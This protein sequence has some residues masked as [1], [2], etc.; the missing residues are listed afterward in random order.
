MLKT[1]I[2]LLTTATLFFTACNTDTIDELRNSDNS[3][4]EQIAKKDVVFIVK[5]TPEIICKSEDFKNAVKMAIDTYVEEKNTNISIKEIET[6]VEKNNVTCETYKPKDKL[7]LK[8]PLCEVKEATD[9]QGSYT[10]PEGIELN[11][12][13]NTSCVVTGDVL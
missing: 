2:V 4:Q 10:L 6:F 13:I 12:E 7:D 11:E 5:H 1:H 8:D 9:I 3:I